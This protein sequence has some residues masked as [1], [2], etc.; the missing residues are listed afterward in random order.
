MSGSN[1]RWVR[2][3]RYALEELAAGEWSFAQFG[4]AVYLA[5]TVN[6]YD[7]K[8]ETRLSDVERDT[9]W[10]W[11]RE[12]LRLDLHSLTAIGVATLEAGQGRRRHV[13][14]FRAPDFGLRIEPGVDQLTLEQSTLAAVDRATEL[15]GKPPFTL[16]VEPN[17]QRI[18]PL[19]LEVT[20]N[21]PSARAPASRV[22]ERAGAVEQLPTVIRL[23]Q[24]QDP[25][26]QKK[27]L[28]RSESA[29]AEDEAPRE[30]DVRRVVEDLRDHDVDTFGKAVWPLAC[31]LPKRLFDDVVGRNEARI[32]SGHVGNHSGSLINLLKLAV[33]EAHVRAVTAA[34]AARGALTPEQVVDA[35][36]RSYA[37]SRVPWDV[38]Q[39][40]LERMI[41]REY[42]DLTDEQRAQ[43]LQVARRSYT[44]ARA[45]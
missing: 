42:G 30:Q 35:D 6:P 24:Q 31:Q 20:S 27:A 19:D 10:P 5:G 29:A 7:G 28:R 22:I 18:P 8:L 32:R 36:A 39:E 13:I 11:S 37:R 16:E 23:Q 38:A 21:D 40:L 3:P 34:A 1:G 25:S 26:D 15:Q 4:L 45:A 41:R 43:L 2:V 44:E 17:L 9:S 33:K 12:K 14:R